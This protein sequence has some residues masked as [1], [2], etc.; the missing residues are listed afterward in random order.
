M[1]ADRQYSR[2]FKML[3]THNSRTMLP[4]LLLLALIMF[5]RVRFAHAI[6]RGRILQQSFPDYDVSNVLLDDTQ[7]VSASGNYVLSLD[8]SDTGGLEASGQYLDYL[9]VYYTIDTNPQVLWL[10]IVGSNYPSNP[11]EVA[12]EPT[13]Q[14]SVRVVGK[15]TCTCETYFLRNFVLTGPPGPPTPPPPCAIPWSAATSYTFGPS[16]LEFTEIL[17]TDCVTS[18]T[19]SMD[20]SHTGGADGLEASGFAMDTL[21][22]FF[23]IDDGAE[24]TWFD[25]AGDAYVPSPSLSVNAGSQLT[26]RLKGKTSATGES[27]VITN[28][29]VGGAGSPQVTPPPTPMPIPNSTP[30][31]TTK[32]PSPA[33][34]LSPVATPPPTPPGSCGP[35]NENYSYVI[36]STQFE[37][38]EVIDTSCAGDVDVSF[39]M[40]DAGDGLES[41]GPYV[42]F[43]KVFYQVDGGREVTWIDILGANYDPAPSVTI[44]S[45]NQLRIRTTGK[46]SCSCETYQ[47]KWIQSNLHWSQQA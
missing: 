2:I 10:D 47:R 14:V 24:Q 35:V 32:A 36:S 42:D 45:G 11:Q 34:V 7:V 4:R 12:V 33:P 31:P 40:S 19:L 3:A 38:I 28:F 13:S 15:T 8:L 20:I 5:G 22:S 25:Y 21:Q 39:Q 26:L 17:S 44:A 23:K 9:E 46:T 27:Y 43:V 30:A 6:L 18:I 41:S 29:A 16:G 1:A 37:A